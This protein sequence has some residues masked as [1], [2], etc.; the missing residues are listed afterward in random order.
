MKISFE[1]AGEIQIAWKTVEPLKCFTNDN[2][3][4]VEA[5]RK[6]FSRLSN[7]FVIS[8]KFS[9]NLLADYP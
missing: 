3:S 9:Y 7:S 2:L 4:T 1:A 6:S 5:A 8:G